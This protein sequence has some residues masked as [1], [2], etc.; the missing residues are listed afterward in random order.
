M[1][2][3]EGVKLMGLGMGVVFLFLILL[4]YTIKLSEKLLVSVTAAE[5]EEIAREQQLASEKR[6]RRTQRGRTDDSTLIAVIS[7]AISCHRR[8]LAA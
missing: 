4:L 7:A 5:L 3:L 8:R 1:I 2:I 6:K